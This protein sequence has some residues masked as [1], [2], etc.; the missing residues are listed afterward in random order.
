MDKKIARVNCIVKVA[1]CG[2]YGATI[3]I[4]DAET[5]E[6]ITE[7]YEE[8]AKRSR[9]SVHKATEE[10]VQKILD[11]LGYRELYTGGS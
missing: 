4:F 1:R 9:N 2:F 11:E 10:K 6:V 7:Q 5:G 8:Y 3:R